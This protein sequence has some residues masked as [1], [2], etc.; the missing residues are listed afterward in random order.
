MATKTSSNR[1]G[2]LRYVILGGGIA[3]C[4]AAEELLAMLPPDC[5]E[6]TM[7]TATPIVKQVGKVVQV[8]RN[9]EEMKIIER[10]ADA[11]GQDHANLRVVQA[12]V[13]GLD[14]SKH[15]VECEGG[16]CLPFDRCLICTGAVPKVHATHE[17]VVGIRDTESVQDLARR[18]ET[19]RRVL[20]LGNGGIALELVH[21]VT[22]C[23]LVWAV[24]DPYV[25]NTFFDHTASG[26]V[27]PE[28]EKRRP[29]RII[30]NEYTKGG[31][32]GKN[33]PKKQQQQQ[34]LQLPL[35]LQQQSA[36]VKE[37]P[38]V[39]SIQASPTGGALGPDWTVGLSTGTGT[40]AAC[41]PE[42]NIKPPQAPSG[43]L[44]TILFRAE[45]EDL[46]ESPP[47]PSSTG[48]QDEDW[49]LWVHLTN[50]QVWGCDFVVSATGV[51]P[52]VSF[53]GPEFERGDDG[54]V[55]VN[56]N[57][58]T[59]ASKDVYAAGDCCSMTWPESEV[60]FQ[61]RLWT[62]ARA[63]ARYAARCMAGLVDELGSGF[64]FE[65]FAHMTR[66]FG[67][68]VA[69]L[70]CF[71][72]QLLKDEEQRRLV[73]EIQV[74]PSLTMGGREERVKEDGG[75]RRGEDESMMG[76]LA[77]SMERGRKGGKEE[78]DAIAKE[79]MS[80]DKVEILTR[81]TP[82]VEY[83]KVLLVGGRV[84]GAMLVGESTELAETFENLIL[85]ELDVS[86]F[87][88]GLLDPDVD[89]DDYFD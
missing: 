66:F 17:H 62:Q 18:L 88:V 23:E 85:N 13:T 57:M 6:V 77:P 82:G 52:S 37:P 34:Q 84:K 59:T 39:E 76:V 53:L 15:T 25:G 63:M 51:M 74:M 22:G 24:K 30:D 7:V 72:A 21:E 79:T 61:M 83:I 44:L 56:E 78:G 35:L 33:D 9:L 28:L 41:N 8:T 67:F 40:P 11:F 71:N 5:A 12:R 2:R 60:W 1:A 80:K 42:A 68:K 16:I 48:N 87:G 65:L 45:I 73:Q 29:I 49:V 27:L 4:T 14:V 32:D 81:L 10:D 20:V 31:T 47:A 64:A 50:G 75:D 54:G 58:Q 26:F 3:G 86:A 43:K 46:Y 69:L 89:I 36:H 70:G 38:A 19:A 55:L